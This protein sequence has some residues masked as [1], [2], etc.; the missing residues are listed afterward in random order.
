MNSDGLAEERTGSTMSS[1]P[2]KGNWRVPQWMRDASEMRVRTRQVISQYQAVTDYTWEA[3]RKMPVLYEPDGQT[4]DW[5]RG[6]TYTIAA[7]LDLPYHLHSCLR[8]L[9]VVDHDDCPVEHTIQPSLARCGASLHPS[10]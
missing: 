10:G 4:C 6:P 9:N 2:T 5:C 8:C 3:P 1:R 7:P